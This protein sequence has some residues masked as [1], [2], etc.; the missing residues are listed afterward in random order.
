MPPMRVNINGVLP[1]VF[2]P[3][4]GNQLSLKRETLNFRLDRK[5]EASLLCSSNLAIGGRACGEKF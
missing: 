2:I 5:P 4:C 3:S 1:H